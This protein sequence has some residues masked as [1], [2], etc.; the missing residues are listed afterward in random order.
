MNPLR[1]RLFSHGR[2]SVK[3]SRFALC[4]GPPAHRTSATS[5]TRSVWLSIPLVGTRIVGTRIVGTK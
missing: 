1:N 4:G 3:L 5:D 2:D